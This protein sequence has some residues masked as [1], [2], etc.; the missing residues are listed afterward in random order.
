MWRRVKHSS[1]VVVAMQ[2]SR[3]PADYAK[4]WENIGK[5][6]AETQW[7]PRN[8]APARGVPNESP[9]VPA[10]GFWS[11]RGLLGRKRVLGWPVRPSPDQSISAERTLGARHAEV[12]RLITRSGV[13]M[14]MTGIAI[15][16]WARRHGRGSSQ[17]FGTAWSRSA[18]PPCVMRSGCAGGGGAGCPGARFRG[19]APGPGS[20]ITG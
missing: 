14:R 13:S 20:R 6:C 15:G 9:A 16:V 8:R 12:V 5:V 18:S 2:P 1:V 19:T 17:G 4:R 11:L 7:Y 3:V 10:A